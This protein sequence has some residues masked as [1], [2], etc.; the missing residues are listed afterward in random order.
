MNCFEQIKPHPGEQEEKDAET[1]TGTYPFL[2][3]GKKTNKEGDTHA[4]N[5]GGENC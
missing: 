5:D 1:D 4:D 2:M 3:K